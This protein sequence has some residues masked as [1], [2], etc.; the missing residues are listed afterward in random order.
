MKSL[1]YYI[2][3]F[4]LTAPLFSSAYISSPNITI[5]ESRFG[6]ERTAHKWSHSTATRER[7]EYEHGRDH[8][9][10]QASLSS[11][12]GD[13]SLRTTASTPIWSPAQLAFV[14]TFYH[15]A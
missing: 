3:K 4:P 6:F 12:S 1:L 7:A 5:G 10:K 9:R 11:D 2:C 14:K 8:K 13:A 15:R